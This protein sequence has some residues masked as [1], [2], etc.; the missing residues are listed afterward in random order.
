MIAKT[1]PI[2]T[3]PLT[4][5]DYERLTTDTDIRYELIDGVLIEMPAP[6]IFHQL[7]SVQYFMLLQ[8]F[9]QARELGKVLYAP[10]DVELAPRVVLQPDIVFVSTGNAAVLQRKRIIGA[11]DLVVELSSPATQARDLGRKR[12]LYEQAG[13]REY[14][15]VD[16]EARTQTVWR[17]EEGRFVVASPEG[18]RIRSPLLP[19]L[20]I[21]V[22]AIFAAAER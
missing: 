22:A 14:W 7:L 13:I 3:G 4:V 6:T 21:D 16:V 20:E 2:Q 15:Y 9:V 19:E 12:E 11:P 1:T 10:V 17:L 8:L 5:D 18:G